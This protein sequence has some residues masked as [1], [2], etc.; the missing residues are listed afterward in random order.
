MFRMA[1][2]VTLVLWLPDLY[3]LHGGATGGAVAVLMVMHLTIALVTYNA[4]IRLAPVQCEARSRDLQHHASGSTAR[5]GNSRPGP[6]RPR[7]GLF[8]CPAVLQRLKGRW[9]TGCCRQEATP[10]CSE[11]ASEQRDD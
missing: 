11:M 6:P 4:L 2:L 7:A 3:I 1:I 10:P 9:A 5:G 8:V